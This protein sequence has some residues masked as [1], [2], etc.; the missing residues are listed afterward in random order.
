MLV[1]RAILKSYKFIDVGVMYRTSTFSYL[2]DVWPYTD[3]NKSV[4]S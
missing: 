4:E 2:V 3:L 1:S